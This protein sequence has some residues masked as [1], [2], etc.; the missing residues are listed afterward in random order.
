MAPS[1]ND[2]LSN[3]IADLQAEYA[4]SGQTMPDMRVG[5]TIYDSFAVPASARISSA[6]QALDV[7]TANQSLLNAATMDSTA[8]DGIAA[9]F[10]QS[11]GTGTVA[12]GVVRFYRMAPAISS[13]TIPV[14]T[15]VS[16]SA[17][18][19]QASVSYMTSDLVTMDSTAAYDPYIGGYYVQCGAVC[20]VSGSAGNTGIDTINTINSSLVGI[21]GVYNPYAITNGTDQQSNADLA[22]AV[23]D[24]AQGGLG[25]KSGYA[26]TVKTN[27]SV[28]DVQVVGPNDAD[29]MNQQ[30][31][32]GVDI[33]VLD[34]IS[35][36][37]QDI[38][39]YNAQ[40][41][42]YLPLFKPLLGV[43]SASWA[44][45][46]LSGSLQGPASGVGTGKDYDVIL[47]TGGIWSGSMQDQSWIVFHP[48]VTL[49]S[50][51]QITV[52]YKFA[53]Q[54]GVI[55]TFFNNDDNDLL[56]SN[57]TVKEG[58]VI[59]ATV[60][61]NI[62]I[63]PGYTWE[64]VHDSAVSAVQALFSGLKLGQAVQANDIL[65]AISDIA[66]VDEVPVSSFVFAFASS[67]SI[68]VDQIAPTNYQYVA[69]A[70][71]ATVTQ[72]Y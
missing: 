24:S 29:S 72:I 65:A 37:A 22:A 53:S 67:P 4:I 42:V 18:N 11:R 63:L 33:V 71:N 70:G 41:P 58:S 3:Y 64:T 52:K 26:L 56:G 66:G 46:S 54:V 12:S 36:T 55:Q 47:D 38:F 19:S 39:P 13:Y 10:G 9:N 6:Y 57:V 16:A 51:A 43:L 21:D 35:T 44:G 20:T 25:T 49:S 60:S 32:G 27:Y 45:A 68:T 15:L 5:V 61:A 50:D 62:S 30:Y 34:S 48:T 2:I 28:D 1:T 69:L 17:T 23:Q 8:V 59:D 31:G 14:N 40:Y 7:V